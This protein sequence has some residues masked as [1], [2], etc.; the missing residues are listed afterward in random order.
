[1]RKEG[2]G[3]GR[4]YD[5]DALTFVLPYRP[6]YDWSRLLAFLAMRAIPA[7]SRLM[8]R[9]WRIGASLRVNRQHAVVFAVTDRLAGSDAPAAPQCAAAA[10]FGGTLATAAQQVLSRTKQVFD[11]GG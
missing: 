5:S 4:W 11:V 1:M 3:E 8:K 9:W 10:L 2:R 7:S 6:P